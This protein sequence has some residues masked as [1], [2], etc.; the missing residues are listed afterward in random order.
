MDGLTVEVVFEEVVVGVVVF[1]WVLVG[2]TVDDKLPVVMF[3]P[4]R[5]RNQVFT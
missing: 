5:R 3:I 1:D 4:E 2:E